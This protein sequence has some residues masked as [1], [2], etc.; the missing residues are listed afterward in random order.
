[1]LVFALRRWNDG[2]DELGDLRSDDLAWSAPGC[3]GVEDND[4]VIVE[5][6]LE[7]AFAVMKHV[8]I[9]SNRHFKICHIVR[10]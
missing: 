8:S 10:R 1:M 5:G 3:E 7:C 4:F 6:G 2:G 9:Y